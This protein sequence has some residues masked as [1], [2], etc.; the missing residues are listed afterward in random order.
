MIALPFVLPLFVI[1]P[2]QF[3]GVDVSII[4][5]LGLITAIAFILVYKGFGKVNA[6]KGGI[7]ILLDIIV[8]VIFAI[9][10]F[11]ELPSKLAIFGGFL[12]LIGAN[13]IFGSSYKQFI[14][15]L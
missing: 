1:D 13:V 4:L 9:I 10:I 2:P 11:G 5:A 15:K 12:I 14:T 7:V 8:P 6:N 3:T